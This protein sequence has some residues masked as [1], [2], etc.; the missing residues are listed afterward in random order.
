MYYILI[1]FLLP[2]C[3]IIYLALP[4][5]IADWEDHN[6]NNFIVFS[7]SGKQDKMEQTKLPK[8]DR[9]EW[10]HFEFLL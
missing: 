3:G 4:S 1:I 5:I 8:T 10:C 9:I 6:I 7:G 2:V